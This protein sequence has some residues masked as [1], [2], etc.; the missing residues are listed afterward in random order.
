[1]A[2]SE[3][4]QTALLKQVLDALRVLQINQSQLVSNVDAINGRVNILAGIKEV[5]D[6]AGT[7]TDGACSPPVVEAVDKHESHDHADVPKSPSVTAADVERAGTPSSAVSLSTK[8]NTNATA[9]IIL[10]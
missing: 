3:T 9:R 7:H 5:E 2:S 6:V 4:D 1:M 10:T 8:R